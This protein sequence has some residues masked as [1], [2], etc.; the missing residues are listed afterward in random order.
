MGTLVEQ[1]AT[2]LPRPSGTPAA[3]GVVS[4]G[5]EPVCDD[6]VHAPDLSELTIEDERA[7]LLVKQIRP[8][9][10]HR[11]EN[12]TSLTPAMGRDQS[13]TIRSMHRNGL[14]HQN[15]EPCFQC[16]DT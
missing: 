2:A 3:R 6:P 16:S 7:D 15:V 13:L 12:L 9:V 1:H 14:L 4:M 5:A 10:E 11:R 8:L